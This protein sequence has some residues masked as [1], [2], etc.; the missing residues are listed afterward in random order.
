MDRILGAARWQFALAY[1]DDVV[2]YS[3]TFEEHLVHLDTVLAALERAGLTISPA[4]CRFAFESVA[5]L[6][7]KVPSLGLMTD[8]DKTR[9]VL[10]F[11]EPMNAAEARRFFAMSAW[12]RRFVK[13]FAA[14]AEP[15]NK[16]FVGSTFVWD[17]AERA[18]FE[19]L[20]A[21]I[22]TAPVL[23]RPDFRR[24]FVLAVDASKQGLGGVLLQTD[25]NG[26]ERPL[27]YVSRQTTDG[28]KR[29][30]PT[31]LELAA[32]W[33]CV[34]K[35]HHYLDGSSLEVR[36]DHN[37]LKWLWDLKPSE[38]H[39]TRVQ[40][41]KMALAPLE[42]KIK[43]SYHRG[44]DNVVADALSRAP[45][46]DVKLDDKQATL[47]FTAR[48]Y[49][50]LPE[51]DMVAAA[52]RVIRSISVLR[53]GTGELD[54]WAAAY[55]ADPHWRRI[56]KRFKT[57]AT[58]DQGSVPSPAEVENEDI[59]EG[60]EGDAEIVA[61]DDASSV[62]LDTEPTSPPKEVKEPTASPRRE[63]RPRRI[64]AVHRAEE[65]S[66][67]FVNDGLLYVQTDETHVATHVRTCYECQANK[68]P[69]H[70]PYGE[71]QPIVTEN[72]VFHTLGMDFI[73]G[74]P[75]TE[76][77]HDSNLNVVCKYSRYAIFIPGCITDTAEQVATRFLNHVYPI[78]G[79]PKAIISD[80]DTRFTS[81]FWS[82]L[83]ASLDI[84]MAMST[85]FHAQTDGL[86]ER[87]NGQLETMLRHYVAI[88]QHDWD[89]KLP[90]LAMAYNSQRQ[91]STTFSP[92][93]LVFNREPSVFPLRDLAQAADKTGAKVNDIF[94][95]HADA[96]AA[97]EIVRER[98]RAGYN[99]RHQ[100]LE[101]AVGDAVMIS[102]KNY[103]FDLDPTE[104]A[105]AKLAARQG[106]PYK[107]K[108]R[109]GRP[110]YELEVP[111]WFRAHPVLP[112]SALE[113]FHGDPDNF[114]PRAQAGVAGGGGEDELRI[115]DFLGRRPT[116]LREGI[117]FDY[118]VKWAGPKSTWQ[119]DSR[120]P[121]LE[122]PKKKFERLAR[123]QLHLTRLS[124]TATII[125]PEAQDRAGGRQRRRREDAGLFVG[126]GG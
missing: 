114:H 110:A 14:R 61:N 19:D 6:G 60:E 64:L 43:I 35:L 45:V 48:E 115:R 47:I 100:P 20:K 85:A 66:I 117:A 68:V 25:D 50:K 23:A 26:E 41:F 57:R 112:I 123:E 32:V 54:L 53:L 11:P 44:K 52:V 33:W 87:I 24:P 3:N 91:S 125:L 65:N 81:A 102:L 29:Y 124:R 118:L 89:T 97:M 78:S 37:A 86:V 7:Y 82:R 121:T 101:F 75:K 49:K 104:N 120:L 31:H 111:E 90:S 34:K 58:A 27:L 69:R 12:Y 79:L 38:M 56:W 63:L 107:I 116:Q 99:S 98:Q 67:F 17:V 84:K 113:P 13:D 71:L 70:K 72:E 105:R 10:D 126:G 62:H 92:Y 1:L 30:A 109:V 22:T 5:L 119:C 9:A 42:N 16:S 108:A 94:A 39:E 93:R 122:W 2:V 46:P 18:A 103:K 51:L 40:K 74:V 95:V 8:E 28:E 15:I 96:Q 73:T 77:G 106:G 55:A 80:R 83:L 4:K 21:A 36:T 59:E 76:L 88:D